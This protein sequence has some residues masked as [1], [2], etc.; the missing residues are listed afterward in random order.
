[1]EIL[2]SQMLSPIPPTA[3]NSL[4]QLAKKMENILVV[5]LDGY[6]KTFLEPK[7]ELGARF[8]HLVCECEGPVPSFLFLTIYISAFS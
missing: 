4:R 5:A 1:M 8:G 3:L 7:V 2:R 6:G